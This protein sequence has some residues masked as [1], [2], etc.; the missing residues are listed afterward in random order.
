M[1]ILRKEMKERRLELYDECLK[2]VLVTVEINEIHTL[3]RTSI[4]LVVFD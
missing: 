1:D 4:L 3:N 2:K